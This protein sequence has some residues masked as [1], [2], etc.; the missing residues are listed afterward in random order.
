MYEAEIVGGVLAA[1]LM[2][3]ITNTNPG[4]EVTH[5]MDSQSVIKA[6]TSR[7]GKTRQYLIDSYR[8]QVTSIH[9]MKGLKIALRWISAHLEVAGNEAVDEA[10]KEV[11][12]GRSSERKELPV[13]LRKGQLV[14]TKSA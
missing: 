5:Y 4:T 6:L 9:E 1:Q 11:A 13:I 2:K 8:R 10:A 14:K 7:K 12:A 3:E